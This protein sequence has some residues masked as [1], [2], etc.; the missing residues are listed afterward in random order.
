[1]KLLLLAIPTAPLAAALLAGIAGRRLPYKG[2]E[3]TVL[4]AAVAFGAALLLLGAEPRAA[5]TWLHTGGYTLTVG[6]MWDGLARALAL[7]VAGIGLLISIYAVGYLAN[8]TD[9]PRFFAAF[10]FFI[11]AMLTLVLAD[12]FVLLFAAWEGVGVASFLLIGFWYQ[13]ED[14]RRAAQK[15]FLLT[16]L[17]DLGLLLGW[18][19]ALH[20]TNTTDITTF[21][22]AIGAQAISTAV[23]SSI[24]LLVFAG[25]VGKSAQ[26][27][28]T[29]WLPDAMAGPTPVSALIHSA[30][31]VAAGIYLLLRLFP[32]FAAIPVVLTVVFWVGG[33]TALVAALVATVQTDLKRIL[34]WSTVSQLGEMM[35]AL[36]LGG[37]LAAAYHLLTHATFKSTLFLA[38]GAIDHATGTRDLRRLGGLARTMP[39]TTL[40]FGVAALALAGVPPLSGFWSEEAILFHAAEA[41][42][43]PAILLLA[44]I[45]LAGVYISRAGVVALTSW[46]GAPQPAGHDPGKLMAVPM[47]VLALLALGFGWVLSGQLANVL[48]FPAVP[49]VG[50]GWRS[51]AVLASLLGLTLGGLRARHRGP[52][53]TFGLFPRTLE[54]GLTWATAVPAALVWRVACAAQRMERGIDHVARLSGRSPQVGAALTRPIE[55]S[56]D[57]TAQAVG[58]RTVVLGS[59]AETTETEGFAPTLD[60]F[61]R[62]FSQAGNRL[63]TLQSGKLYLYTLGLFLWVLVVS[64]AGGILFWL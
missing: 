11:G 2:G 26:L 18:L 12:S 1:M 40:T 57:W 32:L 4:G 28:L 46:P 39:V 27:P 31:L 17:G 34:A 33:T 37:P 61:A 3:L 19:W 59:A 64:V 23:L 25:A 50:W 45:F 53:P 22:A 24:A 49:E 54:H 62:L 16:R 48:R 29:A 35:L 36:G 13:R 52:V 58:T 60:A 21:L 43:A 9:R 30:T 7:L 44:V 42:T 20:L 14:A 47:A 5:T 41:G 63:R 10:G 6:L 56:L 55:H 15:A 38:V 51:A 8:E